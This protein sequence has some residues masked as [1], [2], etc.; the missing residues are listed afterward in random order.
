[1]SVSYLG[2]N[3]NVYDLDFVI[4]NGFNLANKEV[5]NL[6]I[7]KLDEEG[8]D[9]DLCKYKVNLGRTDEEINDMRSRIEAELFDVLSPDER[10][11]FHLDIALERINKVMNINA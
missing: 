4:R 7:G 1:V 2:D 9:T 3:C 8:A 6:F 5:L 10:E 11:N